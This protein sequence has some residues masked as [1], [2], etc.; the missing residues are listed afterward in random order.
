MAVGRAAGAGCGETSAGIGASVAGADAGTGEGTGRSQAL[1]G[2]RVRRGAGATGAAGVGADALK[3]PW[4]ITRLDRRRSG[5][6][7]AGVAET[8]VV[9]PGHESWR[10]SCLGAGCDVWATAAPAMV[11]A[12]RSAIG[13]LW[14]RRK[15]RLRTQD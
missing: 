5:R 1:A 11:V 13:R 9:L 15:G 3:P 7:A 2:V 14:T 4:G 6:V 10:R 12:A 8:V